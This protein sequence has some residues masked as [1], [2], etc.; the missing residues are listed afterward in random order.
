M[1]NNS[2]DYNLE[3]T[4]DGIEAYIT[5]INKGIFLEDKKE[6]SV[7]KEE[8]IKT[9]IKEV[10]DII[11]VGLKEDE[12]IE[13]LSGEMYG[14]KILIAEGIKPIAGKDGY[15]KFKF[16]LDKKLTPK[17]YDDGTV[18]YRELDIINNVRKGDVL[19][20]LISPEEG[21]DGQKVNGEII[22]YKPG[23]PPY[24]RY[25]KNVELLEDGITLV[26]TIDG[27]VKLDANRIIVSE[28]FEVKNVNNE[29]GNINFNGAVL[30][31]EN[32]LNGFQIKADGDVEVYG[33]V[34]GAY[35]ENNGDVVIKRG[36]QGYNRPTI[37]TKGNITTKFVEN[38][39]I[40]ANGSITAEAIMHSQIACKGNVNIV[41]KRGLIV[42]GVCRAGREIKARVIGSSMATST[43]LEVGI[44][45][46][47]TQKKEKLGQDIVAIKDNLDK[48]IKSLNLLES[49][50]KA[51][52]LDKEKAQ[53]YLRLIKTKDNLLKELQEKKD[54]YEIIEKASENCS[55]GM[56]KVSG[57]IYPGVKI[58][59]GNSNYFI[60]DEMERCTFYREEGEIRIGPY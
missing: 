13:I 37:K 10:K 25:G 3:I 2:Q 20:E 11:K 41:G 60:R 58:I 32:A 5:L 28:I 12:L 56:V 27:L 51:N 38:A 16:D 47:I 8:R 14:E 36:I 55:R 39:I 21:K 22:K 6:T 53:M 31:R 30:V 52:R 9:I 43:I 1:Q 17:V 46:N 15:V 59:I 19:A 40:N 49:L 50:K 54:E 18:D 42:G 24:I 48:I 29:T 34:E 44:D 23:K 33:V 57:I 4:R 45:P 26:A 7:D 35:I